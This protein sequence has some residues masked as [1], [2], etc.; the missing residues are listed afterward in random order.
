M[1][2]T[3]LDGRAPLILTAHG[4]RRLTGRIRDALAIADDLLVQAYEG[5]AWEALGHRS[6]VDYCARELPELQ[7][8]KLKSGPRRERAAKLYAEGASLRE[9]A[10]ATGGSLGTTKADV[11][12]F[13]PQPMPQPVKRGPRKTDRVVAMLADRG[14]LDVRQVTKALGCQR[15]EASATLTRLEQARRVVYLPPER[16]GMFGTWAVA[17]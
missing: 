10:A 12:T 2:V 1:T 16:R 6:W 13:R 3:K 11:D 9:I 15:H 7:C 5:R 8:I 17:E 4:A 14:P